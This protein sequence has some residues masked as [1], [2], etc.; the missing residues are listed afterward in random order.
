M[1]NCRSANYKLEPMEWITVKLKAGR[2]IPALAT[3]TAAIAGLQTTELVKVIKGC[4]Y[5]DYRN[6]FLSL[7]V[8]ILALSEPGPVPVIK[9][10]E[11]LK[12]TLWD[13]WEIHSEEGRKINLQTIFNTLEDRYK[14]HP[15]D[16]MYGSKAIY[17]SSLIDI[18]GKEKEKEQMLSKPLSEHIKLDVNKLYYSI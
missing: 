17:F 9:L 10:T 18:P 1:A 8:P 11:D 7:A 6:A 5:K 16:V 14:L 2:I 15:R 3:T 4:E 13:R 12:V